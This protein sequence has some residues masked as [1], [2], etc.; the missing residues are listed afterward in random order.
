[1]RRS[2]ELRT[3]P[4][5][6]VAEEIATRLV[7]NVDHHR[8]TAGEGGRSSVRSPRPTSSRPSRSRP[9]SRSTAGRGRSTSTIKDAGHPPGARSSS[10]PR[11]SSR[12]PSRSSPTPD[13]WV[14]LWTPTGAPTGISSD[15]PR[16]VLWTVTGL[17]HHGRSEPMDA[18][19]PIPRRRPVRPS[20]RRPRRPRARRRVLRRARPDTLTDPVPAGAGRSDGR[21]GGGRVPPHNLA[22]EESLLGAMLLCRTPSPTPSRSSTPPTSTSRPTPHVF[23]AITVAVRAG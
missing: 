8:G 18:P 12:S 1:M 3:P 20:A 17:G 10:T 16:V 6:R 15:I 19:P 4:S 22:A 13:S 21:S 9:A 2:R 7:A 5:A 23:E 14:R 11:C